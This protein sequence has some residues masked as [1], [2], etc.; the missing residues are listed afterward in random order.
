MPIRTETNA[1]NP[2]CMPCEGVEQLTSGG[3][4]QA[5]SLLNQAFHPIELHKDE[6]LLT[7][8]LKMS[9]TL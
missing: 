4:K 6:R 5:F 3:D 8:L 1:V 9:L 7:G 2:T